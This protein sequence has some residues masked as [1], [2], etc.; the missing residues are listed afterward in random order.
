MKNARENYQLAKTS[1]FK[2]FAIKNGSFSLLWLLA[3]LIL[4]PVFGF[5]VD[6]DGDGIDDAWETAHGLNPND[7]SDAL[8]DADGDRIPNLWEYN[9]NT[10][11]QLINSFPAVFD[12]TVDGSQVTNATL[13][14]YATLQEAYNAVPAVEPGTTTPHYSIILVKPWTYTGALSGSTTAKKVLWLGDN[15]SGLVTIK[16]AGTAITLS[17]TTVMDG[18]LITGDAASTGIAV[19]IVPH[20]SLGGVQPRVRLNNVVVD[21]RTS[22]AGSSAPLVTSGSQLTMTHCTFTG[23]DGTLA[24]VLYVVSGSASLVNS[25]IGSQGGVSTTPKIYLAGGAT[26][27][28]QNSVIKAGLGAWGS[29]D[30]DPLLSQGWHLTATSPARG[31][32]GLT[33]GVLTDIYGSSRFPVAGINPDLGAEQ[34]I[35]GLIKAPQG[36]AAVSVSATGATLSW[37]DVNNQEQGS[38]IERSPDGNTFTALANVAA[39]VSS[40]SDSGLTQNTDYYYRVI[41][42]H[43]QQESPPSN[44]ALVRTLFSPAVAPTGITLSNITAHGMR[45]TWTAGGTNQIYYLVQV[46]ADAGVSWATAST[47]TSGTTFADI[48]S[49][50]QKTTYLVR[51]VAYNPTSTANSA[52]VTQRTLPDTPATPGTLSIASATAS[53]TNLVWGD[54]T[55]NE[56]GFLIEQ[57]SNSG[58]TWTTLTTTAAN[59]TSYQ[60]TSLVGMTA[61]QFRVT[62]VNQDGA[63]VVKSTASNVVNLVALP[64]VP[65]TVAPIASS[66]NKVQVTWTLP[67]DSTR[68]DVRVRAWLTTGA[69]LRSV[70]DLPS[71][72]LSYVDNGLNVSTGYQYQVAAVNARGEN[73]ATT[74]SVT[75]PTNLPSAPASVTVTSPGPRNASVVWADN[76][77]NENSFV[78]ERSTGSASGPWTLSSNLAAGTT[79]YPDSGLQGSTVYYY[80]V[81]AVNSYGSTFSAAVAV[82]T[83]A[84][85]T[86]NNVP[87]A[88]AV[89][90]LL[91]FSYSSSGYYGIPWQAADNIEPLGASFWVL[92]TNYTLGGTTPIVCPGVW[93]VVGSSQTHLGPVIQSDAW[94]A[95]S[96]YGKKIVVSGNRIFVSAPSAR[97]D[98]ANAASVRCGA[99]YVFDWNGSSAVQSARLVPADGAAGDRFGD[100]LAG[101]G[102]RVIIGAPKADVVS[103]STTYVDAGRA[104]LFEKNTAGSWVV[105]RSEIS[106]VLETNLQFGSSVA[107]RGRHFVVGAPNQDNLVLILIG[108]NS[109][110]LTSL[111][112]A[113]SIYFGMWD[114]AVAKMT[115]YDNPLSS[116]IGAYGSSYVHGVSGSHFGASLALDPTLNLVVGA[117]DHTWSVSETAMANFWAGNVF[118]FFWNGALNESWEANFSQIPFTGQPIGSG[119]GRTMKW[120]AADRS[121]YFTADKASWYAAPLGVQLVTACNGSAGSRAVDLN[122]YDQDGDP[123][124]YSVIAGATTTATYGGS[125]FLSA[126]ST[127]FEVL[128]DSASGKPYLQPKVGGGLTPGAVYS[129]GVRVA[130]DRTGT[131]DFNIHFLMNGSPVNDADYQAWLASYGLTSADSGTSFGGDGLTTRDKYL[132]YKAGLKFGINPKAWDLDPNADDDGDGIK[133]SED[134][135]PFNASVGRLNVIITQP[136]GAL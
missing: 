65:A 23:N 38:R 85:P 111:T 60:A 45:V 91:T 80:R 119:F 17:D 129:V 74:V 81:R 133:N 1:Q 25:I 36:L 52:S 37:Q 100:A 117:P 51:V 123:M 73:A 92:P 63:T 128:T 55:T 98:P 93:N 121:V 61:Y 67:V 107:V 26:F 106:P 66:W 118:K 47:I 115:G 87:D 6:S 126:S 113:G 124:S 72:A 18:F 54:T 42:T 33:A 112:D 105:N 46:S 97:K 108:F 116:F 130:D 29:L 28:T 4:S 96:E 71:S 2:S 41:A 14:R 103:G 125:N 30:V 110:L 75:T 132:R 58:S 27:T 15:T 9:W 10:D 64:G 134:A 16:V 120:N 114:Q 48:S 20:A 13:K 77:N 69:V 101:D 83:L 102:D 88:L 11:P 76:S 94:D 50:A 24:R 32:G 21:S 34:W 95:S 136:T 3:V 22:S 82:T 7:A 40:Y 8:K 68:T 49:L 44:V 109:W 70:L 131:K 56:T 104:Y 89:V 5:A 43:P 99:V 59:V 90:P 35:D 19:N 53:T 127:G 57:S 62:T 12:A 122:G 39:N 78:V 86:V 135:D 31:L 84:Y 79:S